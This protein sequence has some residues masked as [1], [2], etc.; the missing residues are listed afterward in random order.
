VAQ[1]RETLLSVLVHNDNLLSRTAKS[2]I[3]DTS[4]SLQKKPGLLRGDVLGQ[5]VINNRILV[6]RFIEWQRRRVDVSGWEHLFCLITLGYLTGFEILPAGIFR[7]WRYDAPGS[8][9]DL[10]E[11]YPAEIPSHL[12]AF[13][14]RAAEVKT[15]EDADRRLAAIGA[16][17]WELVV[18]PMHPFYDGCGRISRYFSALL[19]LWNGTPLVRHASREKYFECAREGKGAFESYFLSQ[20]RIDLF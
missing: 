5:S 10:S 12:V 7:E 6:A 9:A 8:A 17:E 18:G 11:V 16:L 3:V 20:E 1:V 19:C 13:G 14:N 15:I 4:A 2:A